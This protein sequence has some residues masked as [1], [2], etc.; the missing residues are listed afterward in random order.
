[1][2]EILE[3]LTVKDTAKELED[4]AKQPSIDGMQKTA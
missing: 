2:K 3:K 1:M 4:T